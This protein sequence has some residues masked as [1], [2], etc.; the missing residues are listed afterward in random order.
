[1]HT[2]I[3][4]ALL[5]YLA[6]VR[7]QVQVTRTGTTTWVVNNIVIPFNTASCSVQTTTTAPPLM[8]GTTTMRSPSASDNPRTTNGEQIVQ[9]RQTNYVNVT[10]H[11]VHLLHLCSLPSV[12]FMLN[13]NYVLCMPNPSWLAQCMHPD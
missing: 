5:K 9:C 8:P 7:M 6:C 13:C 2:N 12:I 10:K 11:I 1:M 4:L 3:D